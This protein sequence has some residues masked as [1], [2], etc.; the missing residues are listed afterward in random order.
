MVSSSWVLIYVLKMLCAYLF[1]FWVYS[2]CID[3]LLKKLL[4]TC[5]TKSRVCLTVFLDTKV[6]SQFV[7][8]LKK[9]ANAQFNQ[10]LIRVEANLYYKRLWNRCW[11]FYFH[12]KLPTMESMSLML[13]ESFCA[14]VEKCTFSSQQQTFN[15]NDSSIPAWRSLESLARIPWLPL[16]CCSDHQGIAQNSRLLTKFVWIHVI[17]EWI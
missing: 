13:V 5:S 7:R 8:A 1:F 10:S 4:L 15:S 12:S 11:G 9:D 16:M 6:R 2:I 3:V 17:Q 14:V